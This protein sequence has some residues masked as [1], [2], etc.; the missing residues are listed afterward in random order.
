MEV[1][2]N[3]S[4]LVLKIGDIT[5][6]TTEAIVNAANAA[7]RGGSGVDGAI[8]RAGGPSI[9][10]ACREIGSC[11]TG[12]A[13][14]TTAG[15]LKAKF[16]IHAVGP[17]YREGRH[18]EEALLSSAYRSCLEMAARHGIESIS[19]PALSAGAYGYPLHEA[20]RTALA[21]VIGYLKSHDEIK[22][23]HFVLFTRDTYQAFATE[24]HH[25]LSVE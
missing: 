1:R 19:F 16:V 22:T 2:I 15:F 23:V 10:E 24:L 21:T 12:S 3:E 13:V 9:M 8:H 7:L 6:E 5:K 11:P 18:N 17:I 20:S 25:L 4:V 14:I